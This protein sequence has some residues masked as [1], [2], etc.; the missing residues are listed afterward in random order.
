MK[1]I[2]IL[3]TT[4]AAAIC[5]WLGLS[6]FD[7]NGPGTSAFAQT[8]EQIQ[9]AKMITW[10]YT[11]YMYVSTKDEK[12][13]WIESELRTHAYK[14]PG[15]YRETFLDKQGQVISVEITDAVNKKQLHLNPIEKKAFLSELSV[16]Q[17]PRGPFA[18]LQK[19]LS[20]PKLQFME[21]RKTAN[22]EINVFR[23]AYHDDSNGRDWSDEYWIDQ[24]TKQLVEMR[25]PG[26]DIF[27]PEKDPAR[28]VTPG[29]AYKRIC[30]GGIM[31][32][33]VYDTE[34]DDSLFSLQPPEGYTLEN[35]KRIYVAEK[36]MIDFLGILAGF[37][38][39]VFP[40]EPGLPARQVNKVWLEKPEKDWTS[41]ERK[42]IEAFNHY[43]GAGMN[44]LPIG[45][46]RQDSTVQESF[47]Y[48]GK[49]VM[50][51]DKDAIV[52]WYK[53]KDAK[54]PDTYR[55]VYGDLSV[56]DVAADDLPLPVEP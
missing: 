12:T 1:R 5:V 14:A 22:G 32:D 15:L 23:H 37:N 16:M 31:H 47:R 41:A 11:F 50:L 9:K 35:K 51:G 46:F 29:K 48:L 10:Q 34:L 55:V 42:Y 56:K 19:E 18:Y 36:E 52:C 24:K 25:V 45:H 4:A 3:A 21:R 54:D 43:V 2:L 13:T 6:H 17:D 44:L 38:G 53:L 8:V 20:E 40:D 39:N 27:D 33:I 49:G 7:T 26:A 28:N 30:A